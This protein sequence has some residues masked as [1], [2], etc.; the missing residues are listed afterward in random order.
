MG[1]KSVAISFWE[2]SVGFDSIIDRIDLDA[3][4]QT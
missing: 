3:G 2:V 4:F 1:K